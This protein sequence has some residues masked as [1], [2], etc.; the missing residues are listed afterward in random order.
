M[1]TLDAPTPVRWP[2]SSWSWRDRVMKVLRM[3]SRPRSEPKTRGVVSDP[4]PGRGSDGGPVASIDK[5]RGQ[6]APAIRSNAPERERREPV[7][8]E[9]PDHLGPIDT[10]ARPGASDDRVVG[11]ARQ[12]LL[13]RMLTRM[14]ARHLSPRTEKTYLSWVKRY[15]AHYGGLNPASLGRADVERFLE[16]LAERL[17]LGAE[18]QNQ[19]ASAIAFMYREVY[20]L[21]YGGRKGVPRARGSKALPRYASPEDVDRVLARLGGRARVAVMIMYGGGLRV[22]EV[23][24]LRVQDVHLRTGELLVRSGKGKRDR[25]TVVPRAAFASIRQQLERVAEQHV[26]D[27][28]RGAGWAPLPGALHRKD[29]QAGW[30]LSWQFLFPSS[31]LSTDPKTGLRG[32]W[33]VHVSTFQRAVKQAVRESGVPAH[34]SCHGF[35]HGFATEMLRNGCDLRLLQQM[36]GHRDLRTTSRYLHI[37][38]RPGLNVISPLDRLPSQREAAEEART[39]AR[40]DLDRWR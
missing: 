2:L 32:R 6:A 40:D 5:Q 37:I 28:E 10:G 23:A 31:R 12:A 29:P 39:Q 20:G 25:T 22:S 30:T 13:D 18:S 34:I 24:S 26:A 15:L 19:A 17:G 33:P 14:R 36:M 8:A 4:D 38:N 21:E 7:L 3:E 35:R 11:V 16:E 27:L 1:P 9:D